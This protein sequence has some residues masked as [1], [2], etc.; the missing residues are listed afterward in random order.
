MAFVHQFIPILC[1][2]LNCNSFF[3]HF[4]AVVVWVCWLVSR[5]VAVIHS[6]LASVDHQ[7]DDC[8]RLVMVQLHFKRSFRSKLDYHEAKGEGNSHIPSFG[9][10]LL[11]LLL[12][13]NNAICNELKTAALQS[14]LKGLNGL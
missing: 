12:Q 9:L 13:F 5:W 2:N 14:A 1:R 6:G 8:L 7:T 3:L 11:L 10:M 4:H